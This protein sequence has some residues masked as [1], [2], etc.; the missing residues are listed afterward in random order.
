M[1]RPYLKAINWNKLEDRID[2]SAWARLNDILW[3]PNRIPLHED[4]GNFAAL[5][6]E[7]QELVLNCL[8][9]LALISTLQSRIGVEQEKRTSSRPKKLLS[10]MPCNSWSPLTTRATQLPSPNLSRTTLRTRL[11]GPN[12][13][14]T[15]KTTCRSCTTST[16]TGPG[17]KKRPQ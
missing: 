3:E 16:K 12:T 15:C 5:A 11:S 6:P 17:C 2:K 7:E 4:R 1:S 8:G 13:T 9:Q 14:S 10:S